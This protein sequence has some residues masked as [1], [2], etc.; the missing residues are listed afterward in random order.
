MP[1]PPFRSSVA[2]PAETPALTYDRIV[3]EL[4]ERRLGLRRRLGTALV[5]AASA[6]VLEL[7]GSRLSGSLA[8]LSDAGHVGTDALAL[9]LSLWAV[10][11]SERPHTPGMS[12][13]YHR[14]EVLAALV[15]GLL[16]VGLAAYLLVEAIGRA[17]NPPPVEGGLMLAVGLAGLTANVAMI[18]LLRSWARRNI[19][20][21]GAFLHAYGDALGSV[22]VVT[23]AVL[24]QTT[25]LVALDLL[26]AVFIVALISFS[27]VRLLREGVH[28]VLEASPAGV[29]PHQ[30]AQRIVSVP[31]VRAVHDLHIWTVTS[32]LHWLT[33][34]ILVAGDMTVKEAGELVDRIQDL[35]R[36]D[37]GIAHATLQAESFQEEMIS[38]G[39]VAKRLSR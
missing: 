22:G 28:I 31:G 25:G 10:A 32:G 17:A 12:F 26:V 11:V 33:G 7:V 20:I 1:R 36:E 3:P 21:R 5:I 9:G 8:L 29:P 27:A 34:H 4:H 16:L 18:G 23:A 6:A 14:I 37:F 30:V 39:D 15:N 19:N 2:G 13:G 35:L 38:P 24:I